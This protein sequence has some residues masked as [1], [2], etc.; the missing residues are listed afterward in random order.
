[1]VTNLPKR[2]RPLLEPPPK[3]PPPPPP[4]PPPKPPLLE[5]PLNELLLVEGSGSHRQDNIADGLVIAED[6]AA[7]DAGWPVLMRGGRREFDG[8]VFLECAALHS[9]QSVK[10]EKVLT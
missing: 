6:A 8:R 1:M 3:P 9:G 4:P 7:V 2:R 5:L 10:P